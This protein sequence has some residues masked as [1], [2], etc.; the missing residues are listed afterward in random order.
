ME[1]QTTMPAA[2]TAI[3]VKMAVDAWHA[4]NGRVEK[5]VNELTDEQLAR[6]TA[7]GRNTGTYLFG[8]L[9]AVSDRLFDAMGWGGRL[10]PELDQIFLVN[11]D[12]SGNEFPPI[13]DLRKYWTEINEKINKHIA[14]MQPEDWFTKHATVSAEDFV[15]EPHRNK[16]NLLLSRAIHTS[17]HQG[18]MIYLGEK[19]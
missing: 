17:N 1:T 6:E 7:P 4:Q 9:I 10:H 11:P 15:K 12:K 2:Q 19:K 3:F 14:E 18:Q 13:A 16:L 8:H 5:L